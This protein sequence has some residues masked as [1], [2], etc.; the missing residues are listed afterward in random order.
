MRPLLIAAVL[1]LASGS[2]W[3]QQRD[4][5]PATTFSDTCEA[6]AGVD[7]VACL[8]PD[9]RKINVGERCNTAPE[10]TRRTYTLDEIDRMRA[11]ISARYTILTSPP[12]LIELQV[13]ETMIAGISPEAL[14]AKARE[15]K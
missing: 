5:L 8:C 6:A 9:G 11:A 14:E 12:I 3:G 13:I 4:T 2:A 15:G 7:I 1:A 10:S